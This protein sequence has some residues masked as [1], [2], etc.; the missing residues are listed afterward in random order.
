MKLKNQI[1]KTENIGEKFFK[2]D[3]KGFG[4]IES[5]VVYKVRTDLPKII[6]QELF[7]VFKGFMECKERIRW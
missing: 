5:G 6:T 4:E 3:L 7:I 1:D 2:E